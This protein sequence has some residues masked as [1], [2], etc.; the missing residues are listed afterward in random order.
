MVKKIIFV[1]AVMSVA[2]KSKCSERATGSTAPHRQ[3]IWNVRRPD[4]V[5]VFA[6][7]GML[8]HLKQTRCTEFQLP[9]TGIS[10]EELNAV[11]DPI[12]LAM[13]AVI[14]KFHVG[15]NLYLDRLPTTLA[16]CTQLRQLAAEG[17]RLFEALPLATFN[18]LDRLNVAG[19]RLSELHDLDHLPLL[20]KLY[21]DGNE[22]TRLDLSHTINLRV[23]NV[24]GN[25]QLTDLTGIQNLTHLTELDISAT[26]FGDF[27]TLATLPNLSSLTVN[28]NA[29]LPVALLHNPNL[30]II[31]D[32]EEAVNT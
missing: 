32:D 17:C 14:T 28:A 24:A 19:N 11:F 6:W 16:L 26:N 18:Q 22:L 10:S 20:T 23:L 3:F 9:A 12:P 2:I 7:K 15:D 13:K 5:R 27:N 25:L 4:S 1:L 30:T 29:H 8:E 21:A 31:R